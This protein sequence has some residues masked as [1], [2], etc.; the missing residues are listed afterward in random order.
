MKQWIDKEFDSS[1]FSLRSKTEMHSRCNTAA[2]CS[3]ETIGRMRE[4]AWGLQTWRSPTGS[5][6]SSGEFLFT[7]MRCNSESVAGWYDNLLAMKTGNKV[8]ITKS[9]LRINTQLSHTKSEH[10][11]T[12][13]RANINLK[14]TSV[15]TCA[16]VGSPEDQAGKW[17]VGVTRQWAQGNCTRT[18]SGL[19]A[20]GSMRMT[21]CSLHTGHHSPRHR[22]EDLHA[23]SNVRYGL[24][25]RFCWT[26][27]HFVLMSSFLIFNFKLIF[28]QLNIISS[29]C[30]LCTIWNTD[31][32]SHIQYHTFKNHG[33]ADVRLHGRVWGWMKWDFGLILPQK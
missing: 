10:V 2:F 32:K 25:W 19:W 14:N 23:V 1:L 17:C 21:P 5:V 29:L 27:F 33:C 6:R 24:R 3:V 11:L 20:R 7:L 26:Y 31:C 28:L 13:E 30:R 12:K 8:H 4:T 22:R 16:A 9:W 15:L 18:H